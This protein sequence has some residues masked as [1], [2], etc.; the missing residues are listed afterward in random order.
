MARKILMDS[1]F[2]S[3]TVHFEIYAVHTPTNAI[4][5]NLVKSLNFTLEFKIVHFNVKL[6]LITKLINSAFVG[7]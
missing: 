2:Y 3:C 6:K 7:V 1:F 5:I 4:F